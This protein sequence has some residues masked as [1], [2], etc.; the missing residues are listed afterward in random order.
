MIRETI[1]AILVAFVIS[2]VLCPV[3][4]PFLRRLKFGQ[5]IRN[6]GPQAHLK[7]SG[8]PTMGGIVFLISVLCTSL[9]YIKDFPDIVPILFAMVGFGIVGFLDDYLKIVMKRSEGLKPKQKLFGQLIVSGVLC[10]Y[11]L[12][13]ANDGVTMF[14]PFVRM[15]LT[16]PWY[17]FAPFFMFALLATD[18]G[19]NLTDG[20][21]WAIRVRWPWA[22]LWRLRPLACICP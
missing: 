15:T 6:D 9:F 12:E 18:N 22:G 7:K 13:M 20:C 19:V 17:L 16:L 14:I 8:T 10:Y 4:I 2:A 5:Q 21:L 11:F 1:V 3:M